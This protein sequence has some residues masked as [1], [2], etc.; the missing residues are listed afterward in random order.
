MS[1]KRTHN[2]GNVN[3]S[4]IGSKVT[5]NGWVNRRRD[6]GG[7]IFIDLRDR[8]GLVQ[9]VFNPESLTS[10]LYSLAESLRHEYVIS[11]TG[12]V[13]R[14]P[15]G[16]VNHELASG[17]IEVHVESLKLLSVAK[18][19]PFHI[20]KTVDVDDSL[21]LKYRYLDL[22]HR[23]LQDAIAVR[24]KVTH[25][26]RNFLNEASFLEI[27]TPMLTRSTPE[28]ARDYVV[29]SR[30]HP[31]EFYALPQSPQIFKQLLMIAGFERYFQIARCF[32]DEDLRA[33]RQPEFTQIDV[34]MS[35]VDQDDIMQ[36]METMIIKVFQ[37]ITGKDFVTPIKRLSYEQSMLRFGSD[38]PD[39]R[40]GLEIVDLSKL[41]KASEFKVFANT[42]EGG[43]VVRGINAKGCG[44]NFSRREID[45]LVEKAN[46]FGAKG[47][48]WLNI[49]DKVKSPITK[50]LHQEEIEGICDK[51]QGETGDLLLLVADKEAVAADVLG[52]L[53]LYLGA[54][55]K[56]IDDA[57]YNFLW[58]TDWPLYEFN[59]E[60]GRYTAAHHPFTAPLDED[61]A[62]M[63]VSPDKVRAK[64]YDLVLN[65]VELGG[66]SIRIFQREVQEQ[67]FKSLGFTEQ[68]AQ[69]KFGFLLEAFE[70][71]AP[72]H[73]GIAFGLDRLVMLLTGSK[74]I[75]D[76]IAFPKTTS[77]LDL[78]TEAPATISDAQ[79]RELKL[80]L[81][82]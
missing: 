30:I 41:L 45:Q 73:G 35:F 5:L 55:L 67:M 50:F 3:A 17:E 7:L 25:I 51:L 26:V 76:V 19:P 53:R 56:L 75:R 62:L 77:A 74:S 22:R 39:T 11:I 2:C 46:E 16:Q 64:A 61:L 72:P 79:L 71:G 66:G 65:G 36:L 69:E 59:E 57:K 60:E 47:L 27:E 18:T 13:Q 70:Y 31:G 20:D 48:A 68:E 63:N 4:L 24:H 8:S 1:W 33:D 15:E 54:K 49:S 78:M 10:E 81:G 40:F 28:G 80:K 14:R 42:I 52:R 58:I 34:E 44:A 37:E 82:Q 38:R 6:L 12:L 23:H 32:R 43:G 21:L 9:V 29:P